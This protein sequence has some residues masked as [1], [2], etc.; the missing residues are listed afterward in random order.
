MTPAPQGATYLCFAGRALRPSELV[1]GPAAE[2]RTR[3][4]AHQGWISACFGVIVAMS[5]FALAFLIALRERV[6]ALY[7]GY[8]A[9]FLLFLLTETKA[10]HRL[11]L[12]WQLDPEA[13]TRLSGVAIDLA[14][15]LAL[16]FVLSFTQLRRRL[17][18]LAR[19]MHRIAVVLLPLAAVHGL[20]HLAGM[21]SVVRA[22]IHASNVL[23]TA[24]ALSTLVGGALAARG[25]DR[26]ARFLL[27]G[28][29]PLV[30]AA[31]T[32]SIQQIVQSRTTLP[33][34]DFTLLAG[35]FES[36]VLAL[37]LADRTLSYRRE[38]ASA[39]EMADRDALSGLLNRRALLRLS[40]ALAGDSRRWGSSLS[41]VMFDLDHFKRVNDEHGHSVG[42]ACIRRF[43][44]DLAAEARDSDLVARYG[45]EEFL[46][47]LPGATA[48]SARSFAERVRSR[49]AARAVEADGHLVALTVSAGAATGRSHD[50]VETLIARADQA[51][52]R[53]KHGGRNQV[54]AE[55]AV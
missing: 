39:R 25:G 53:A 30:V 20:A 14:S 10:A 47:V 26:Y 33:V 17:P 55:L 45:G 9:A 28:W 31:T 18:R 22:S 54:A 40:D 7:L 5:L 50:R 12:L 4:L 36:V 23:V 24:G 1:L 38:L 51:L 48:F 13:M 52:Y 15:G 43:A 6:F 35:T 27:V 34:L 42:D 49:L 46:A 32:A 16:L 21:S 44:E 2:F 8:L 3:D 11:P 37:G 29:T 41:V 19:W